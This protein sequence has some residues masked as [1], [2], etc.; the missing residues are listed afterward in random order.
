MPVLFKRTA[1]SLGPSLY[2]SAASRYILR[3]IRMSPRISG[4][5]TGAGL[6]GCTADDC[7]GLGSSRKLLGVVGVDCEATPGATWAAARFSARKQ[8]WETIIGLLRGTSAASDNT[9]DAQFRE[10]VLYPLAYQLR[11]RMRTPAKT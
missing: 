6:G 2:A 7:P 5:I 8:S 9:L 10:R 4:E 3:A 1:E 11:A